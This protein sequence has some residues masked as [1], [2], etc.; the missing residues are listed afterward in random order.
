MK[1]WIASIVLMFI[2]SIS[3]FAADTATANTQS[4]KLPEY[5]WV[6]G[7]ASYAWVE[8]ISNTFT[9]GL[10][11]NKRV[12]MARLTRVDNKVVSTRRRDANKIEPGLRLVM[13]S[14]F[15]DKDTSLVVTGSGVVPILPITNGM[16]VS[17]N[18]YQ[19]NLEG[20]KTYYVRTEI[21]DN[22]CVSFLSETENGTQIG[23][24][25]PLGNELTP[26]QLPK[27]DEVETPKSE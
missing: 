26:A 19:V 13:L 21:K 3:V 7:S 15:F 25:V 24:V 20:N 22:N 17:R 8:N 1:S 14:C 12:C 16:K 5:D 10:L 23:D 27:K 9:C 18:Q 11:G 4:K 2:S 6:P